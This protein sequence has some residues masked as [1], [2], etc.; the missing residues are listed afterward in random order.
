MK[1]AVIPHVRNQEPV[2]HQ[3]ASVET[4]VVAPR[5]DVEAPITAPQLPKAAEM[6][7]GPVSEKPA[8]PTHMSV[9]LHRPLESAVRSAP[10]SE[11]LTICGV[12]PGWAK[13]DD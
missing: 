13:I 8:L 3:V 2:M 5:V 12:R 10:H 7:V 4:P 11:K 6:T 1:E 9:S